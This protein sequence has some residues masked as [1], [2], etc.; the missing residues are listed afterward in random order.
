MSDPRQ[1]T[2]CTKTFAT[3]ASCR[4]HEA[5]CL[6]MQEKRLSSVSC[7][8]C[9]KVFNNSSNRKR[10]ETR[11]ICHSFNTTTTNSHNTTTTITDSNITINITPMSAFGHESSQFLLENPNFVKKC[12]FQDL[13]GIFKL[14]KLRNFNNMHPENKNVI[15]EN[16]RDEFIRVYNGIEWDHVPKDDVIAD[17]LRG[18]TNI[19]D[20][21]IDKYLDGEEIE[22]DDGVEVPRIEKLTGRKRE[23]FIRRIQGYLQIM[24]NLNLPIEEQTWRGGKKNI[25]E[26]N[27]IFKMADEFIYNNSNKTEERIKEMEKEIRLLKNEL[28]KLKKIT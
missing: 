15:K 5:K 17:L 28:L 11:D 8:K 14:M 4:R 21:V 25:L 16:K 23:D 20:E 18:T 19:T 1:C 13:P 27:R 10:H 7:S 12:I 2:H 9:N 26:K 6:E 3:T 22:D 24:K